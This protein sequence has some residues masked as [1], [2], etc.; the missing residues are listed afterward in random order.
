MRS[1]LFATATWDRPF[2]LEEGDVVIVAEGALEPVA[3]DL[4]IE[5][6]WVGVIKIKLEDVTVVDSAGRW[7]LVPST[8]GV[9]YAVGNTVEAQ[10]SRGVVRV[11]HKDPIRLV[12]FG[13]RV[14]SIAEGFKPTARPREETFDDFG[15]LEIGRA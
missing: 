14:E 7:R 3:D 8:D 1:G 13:E 10:D 15:G 12:D 6:S 5:E 11:L 2:D 4:W 9:D